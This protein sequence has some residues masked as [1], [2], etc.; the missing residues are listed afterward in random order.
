M[1]A[2]GTC[3]PVIVAGAGPTGLTLATELR[4]G[5]IDVLLLEHLIGAR[6]DLARQ[7]CNPAP[8]RCSTSGV[9]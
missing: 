2:Q 5:G 9:S 1:S 4:R 3:A 7:G 8:S 6:T